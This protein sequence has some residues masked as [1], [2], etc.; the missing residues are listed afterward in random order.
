MIGV[1]D[2]IKKFLSVTALAASAALLSAPAQ[3]QSWNGAYVGAFGGSGF[4]GADSI[5]GLWGG[6]NARLE[7]FVLGA[8]VEVYGYSGSQ[9]DG[10]VKAR[11]G[12][13]ANDSILVYGTLGTGRY[14]TGGTNLW[15]GGV[16]V[17]FATG[18]PATLRLEFDKENT[19]GSS[20]SSGPS[21][22]KA[23]VNWNF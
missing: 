12:Y 21:F 1:K 6:Y 7:D 14:L 3:A 15:L 19:T 10:F 5:Y 23:G 16:G 18:G 2:M 8:E 11:V 13:V 4:D 22:V 17:E 9:S 20:L